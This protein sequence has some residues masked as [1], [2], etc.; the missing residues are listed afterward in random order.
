MD[1]SKAIKAAK[2]L[3]DVINNQRE[4]HCGSMSCPDYPCDEY[5]FLDENVEEKLKNFYNV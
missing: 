1:T 3:A 2:K 4:H 5:R